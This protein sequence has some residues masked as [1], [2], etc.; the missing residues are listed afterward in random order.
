MLFYK[1]TIKHLA[2]YAVLLKISCSTRS[3]C[4][5]ILRLCLHE[6]RKKLESKGYRLVGGNE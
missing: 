4:R 3:R 1:N 5:G 6:F 2:L